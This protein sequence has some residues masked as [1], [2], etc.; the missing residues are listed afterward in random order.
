[1]TI[2]QLRNELDAAR[3]RVHK[4]TI[5][6]DTAKARYHAALSARA[7][8][9]IIDADKLAEGISI[10]TESALVA[11][12]EL[13]RRRK[14]AQA[15]V[16]A[17]SD[18]LYYAETQPAIDRYLAALTDMLTD[19]AEMA[20]RIEALT[21]AIEHVRLT[22][23]RV[24]RVGRLA[25]ELRATVTL[26]HKWRNPTPSAAGRLWRNDDGSV[27]TVSKEEFERRERAERNARI[28]P[29]IPKH[30]TIPLQF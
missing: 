3:E 27:V 18:E 7:D 4:L 15:Q 11:I 26:F 29:P 9:S 6:L 21:E 24:F 14:D 30:G 17:L 22:D 23:P 8:L 16:A 2:E 1:M 20:D 19:F 13:E 28:L 12:R 10:D 25:R 5:A